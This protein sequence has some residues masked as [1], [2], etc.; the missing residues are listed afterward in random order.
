MGD[1]FAAVCQPPG[2]VH[3]IA[4]ASSPAVIG[5][6]VS[7]GDAPCGMAGGLG[8]GKASVGWPEGTGSGAAGA[9]AGAGGAA[10]LRTA[11]QP[12]A[13]RTATATTYRGEAQFPPAS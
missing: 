9:G 8:G 6:G 1:V 5:E 13:R 11:A 2:T 12:P 3:A 7:W 10:G 4:G